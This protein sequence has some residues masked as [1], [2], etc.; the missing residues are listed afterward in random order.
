MPAALSLNVRKLSLELWITADY[1]LYCD[2]I[3]DVISF[4]IA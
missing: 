3:N 4:V 1:Y 2:N